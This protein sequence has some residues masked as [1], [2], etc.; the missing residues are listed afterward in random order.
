MSRRFR[1][2]AYAEICIT[3]VLISLQKSSLD[4]LALSE[5]YRP[6]VIETL[7]VGEAPPPSGSSYF[8]LPMVLRKTP[9]I[10]DNRSLPATIF[11]HY[12]LRLPESTEEYAAFL[13][14]LKELGVFL[15]DLFDTPIQVRNSPEGMQQIVGALPAF[16]DKLKRRSIEVEDES[17]VFLLAR[18]SYRARIRREFPRSRLV[19]WIDFRMSCAKAEKQKEKQEGSG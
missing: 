8:Y 4:Y 5:A 11:H 3:R 17:I 18:T 13:L 1:Q 16:R 6:F 15:V 2:K 10:R 9:S 14:Q 12:F 19:R 7:L